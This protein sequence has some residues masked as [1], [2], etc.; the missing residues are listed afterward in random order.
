M[1]NFNGNP[2]KILSVRSLVN[3]YT[4]MTWFYDKLKMTA[5]FILATSVLGTHGR[6]KD[7][8]CYIYGNNVKVLMARSF[9]NF[10]HGYVEVLQHT[11]N[12]F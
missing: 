12:D 1:L 8:T 6:N 9:V 11:L 2:V 5:T 3:H 10:L 4:D 7:L